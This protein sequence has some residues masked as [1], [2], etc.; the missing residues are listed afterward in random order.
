MMMNGHAS[1]LVRELVD[2]PLH[3]AD[4]LGALRRFASE[5]GWRP[6][7]QLD[8][9]P[10]T[11]TFSNGHLV[12]EH[13]FDRTAVISFLR[14][15]TPYTDLEPASRRVLLELSYNNLVDWHLLP[16]RS[17]MRVVFNRTDPPQD[18]FF[19]ATS[20]ENVW[21]AEAFDKLTGKR[22]N[23]NVKALDDALVLTV[24]FWK[25]AMQ[26]D[27]RGQITLSQVSAMI[28]SVILVRALEDCANRRRTSPTQDLLSL[29]RRGENPPTNAHE[30]I[31]A[32][33]SGL[34]QR[35]L[36]EWLRAMV[37]ELRVFDAWDK[38]ALGEM[39]GDF[40]RSKYS[41]Y[42]Y[43]FELISKHA[44]SRI[45]EHY[46]AELRDV[47][48]PQL[49]LFG[50]LPEEVRNK[51]L[52]SFY[53]PQYIARFF[54][55]YIRENR[56]PRSFR[57]LVTLDPAC[58][59]G[60][61]LRTLLE[62]QCDPSDD[63]F[64]SATVR[65]A[66][67]NTHGI[68]V[69]PNACQ[70][71]RLSLALL[72]L[73]LA[74]EF[75]ESLNIEEADAIEKLQEHSDAMF[76]V[77]IAN[78]PFVKWDGL[79]LPI[80]ER[81][82]TY[83][84]EAGL[85]KQDL[86]LAFLRIAMEHTSEGGVICFVLPH[87]FLLS[88]SASLLRHKLSE[89]FSVRVLAD[90][91]EVPVFEQ[92]GAY[93]ILLIA[94][95]T[96]ERRRPAVVVKCREFVG[97]ALQDALTAQFRQGDAYQVFEAEQASFQRPRWNL[98]RPNEEAVRKAIEAF[99]SLETFVAVR[100]GVVTGLDEVFVR[101]SRDCPKNERTVWPPLLPD[102]EMLRFGVPGSQTTAVFMPFDGEGKK[103]EETEL[104]RR[105]PETWK[106]LNGHKDSL[107]RRPAVAKGSLHWWEPERPR[108]PERILVPKIVTPH[109]VL[110]PR[111]GIDETG[112]YVVSHSPYLV[113]DPQAGSSSLLKIVCAV[114]NS[115]VGHW[116]LAAS[117]HKYSRGYLML[118]VKTLKDF[119]M[120]D[121]ASL[122]SALTRKIVRLVDKLTES[123]GDSRALEEL[124]IA[125]GEAFGLSRSQL[126]IVGVGVN[127]WLRSASKKVI[128]SR[129]KIVC[130]HSLRHFVPRRAA[131]RPGS[132]SIAPAAPRR[133]WRRMLAPGNCCTA[134]RAFARPSRLCDASTLSYGERAETECSSLIVPA[135]HSCVLIR[136]QGTS[137]TCCAFIQ[138]QETR[139]SSN[140]A[141]TYTCHVPRIPFRIATFRSIWGHLTSY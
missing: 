18:Q 83:M 57:S 130:A 71:T 99:P 35:P 1:R 24:S 77:V 28:N 49:S 10:G 9:Y 34:Y 14:T 134:R 37:D 137:P 102:R 82:A 110:M 56:T 60:M 13:G 86:Y 65:Q 45:Y 3:G 72:H 104:R 87:S 111:F 90:L 97:A 80:R 109:L 73:V 128:W 126:A 61:F 84:Q 39:V 133:S 70:A 30:L 98:L 92:M 85:G 131:W 79:S 129:G 50:T 122:P 141:L 91:S 88:K 116:Q 33:L 75:P 25:R 41:K 140:A 29:L 125:V 20:S 118:E 96:A 103:L 21:R 67:S 138:T 117:S 68:D 66:F 120:P 95:R 135:S 6:S 19:P 2:Q 31:D 64:S 101:R 132:L 44:L 43:N 55:R 74:D 52:G 93:V 23:P 11:E 54:S 114:L 127:E 38:D 59:S 105:C 123:P 27:L 16:E 106:Y 124:D 26:S 112:K 76:D 78:P 139:R 89:D 136:L 48:T 115:A 17:G 51:D 94:E 69:D 107:S 42:R 46:V 121:P 7:D 4:A 5:F 40:Y 62:M 15:D 63:G 81:I 58:G 53:T 8:R 36:P 100:Q 32:A 119:H 113:A 47:A 22:P 12:V 108:K